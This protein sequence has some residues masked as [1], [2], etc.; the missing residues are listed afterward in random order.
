MD[1]LRDQ[2]G[3]QPKATPDEGTLGA[4]VEIGLNGEL[5]HGMVGIRATINS[6][7]TEGWSNLGE[8][9]EVPKSHEGSRHKRWNIERRH[10]A[11]PR[12]RSRHELLQR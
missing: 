3:E 1:A 4:G 12:Q 8:L 9:G 5:T 10:E 2:V 6:M 11:F 7:Q